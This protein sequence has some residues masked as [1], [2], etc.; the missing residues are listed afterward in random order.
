MTEPTAVPPE[1][2][3]G[4]STRARNALINLKVTSH[5]DLIALSKLKLP[6]VRGCGTKTNKE[7]ER[8]LERVR[9]EPAEPPF[10]SDS[11]SPSGCDE[12]ATAVGNRPEASSGIPIVGPARWSILNKTAAELFAVNAS[13]S[14][15]ESAGTLRLPPADLVRLRARGI[16]PEDA[17]HLLCSFTVGY[18]LE[19]GLSDQAM[20]ALLHAMA[21]LSG[22]PGDALP[23]P[24]VAPADFSLYAGFPEGLLDPLIVPDFAFPALLDPSDGPAEAVSWNA[25]AKIT[26]RSVLQTLGS[27]ATGLRAIR[28]LWQLQGHA[29]AVAASAAAGMSTDSYLDFGQLIDRYVRITRSGRDQSPSDKKTMALEYRLSMQ[30]LAPTDEKI[31]LRKLGDNFGITGE[32]VRQ[33]ETKLLRRL[34]DETHLGLLDYLWRLLDRLMASGGGGRYVSELCLSLQSM[35][36]WPSP[37]SEETLAFIMGLSPRYR[38]ATESSPLRV[39]LS[40]PC[41]IGCETAVSAVSEALAASEHGALSVHHALNVMTGACQNLQCPELRKIASFSSSLVE[42]ITDHSPMLTVHDEALHLKLPRP[43]FPCQDA[44]ERILLSSPDGMHFTE[45]HRRL[46]LILP[47]T[48]AR[49]QSVYGRLTSFRWA[50]LWGVGIFKHRACLSIPVSLITLILEEFASALDRYDI[51]YLCANGCYYEGYADRLKAEGV[52]TSRAFYSCMKIVGSPTLSLEEF[53]YVLRKDHAGPRPS[54][55]QLIEQHIA[56]AQ[57]AVTCGEVRDFEVSILGVPIPQAANHRSEARNILKIGNLL[58]HI[59]NVQIMTDELRRIV[60]APPSR[61]EGTGPLKVRLFGKHRKAC[62]SIGII[63]AKDLVRFV[64]HF[65]PGTVEW[66]REHRG[67][68]AVSHEPENVSVKDVPA[69]AEAPQRRT[70]PPV[71]WVLSYLEDLAKPCR[72][73]DIFAAFRAHPKQLNLYH[74]W[75]GNTAKVLWYTRETVIARKILEWDDDKQYTIEALALMHLEPLDAPCK[76]Y[77]SCCEVLRDMQGELPELP[78]GLA[79]TPFLLHSLLVS[80]ANFL[81]IGRQKDFFVAKDNTFGIATLDDL[82]YHALMTDYGGVV[83][84]KSLVAAYAK[85]GINLSPKMPFLTGQDE[86]VVVDGDVIRAVGG[87][88]D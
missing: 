17:A 45:A 3:T 30:R 71:N 44:L 53:P 74:R 48:S 26:E 38:V 6:R 60:N 75:L 29:V 14:C 33:V 42:F 87:E 13:P 77:G 59:D 72:P 81:K 40:A 54:I 22:L 31:P 57:R 12:G 68:K 79:W 58:L 39:A 25:V 66:P 82:L 21:R 32:R 23:T 37:P 49:A 18:L 46:R 41:C 9:L 64:E 16:F 20:S 76:P 7:L 34:N 73:K 28:Y 24:A 67:R 27:S 52:P 61:G 2:L 1:L 86:R 78:L 19:T 47:E 85:L 62:E 80:G 43:K 84:K 55:P 4:L 51:P 10:P 70:S 35:H 11:C 88:L 5:K 69:T 36:G 63:G 50:V 83:P 65:L 8:L 56:Q 15:L